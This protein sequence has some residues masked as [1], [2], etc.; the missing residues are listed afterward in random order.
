[1]NPYSFYSSARRDY[2]ILM[3]NGDVSL[4]GVALSQMA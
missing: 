3:A 1:M 2:F 4:D